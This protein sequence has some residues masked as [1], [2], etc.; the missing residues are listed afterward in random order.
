[1]P[2]TFGNLQKD[3]SQTSPSTRVPKKLCP[4]FSPL[5]LL[6]LLDI[7]VFKAA[8]RSLVIAPADG[9]VIKVCAKDTVSECSNVFNLCGTDRRASSIFLTT[10]AQLDLDAV[11]FVLPFQNLSRI[12]PSISGPHLSN[13]KES[14]SVQKAG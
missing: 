10:P 1:M 14:D 4:F 11:I 8:W 12:L 13:H 5:L 7:A 2:S 9:A 6:P 3:V